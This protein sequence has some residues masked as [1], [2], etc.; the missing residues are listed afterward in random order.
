V[1][2]DYQAVDLVRGRLIIAHMSDASVVVVELKDGAVVKVVPNVPVPRG[3]AVAN[4]VKRVFVTSSPHTLVVL[5]ADSLDEIA[6]IPTGTA[7]DGVAWDGTHRVVAVSAQTDGAVSLI[8]DAGSGK[9]VDVRLGRETGNVVYD[10]Q[11]GCFWVAVE[12]S[13]P[14][15]ALVAVD[16][17][18]GKKLRTIPLPGC[19]AAHG[20]L[21]PPNSDAAFVACEDNAHLARVPL[22][23]NG[24]APAL[25][26]TGA[27]PDVLAFDAGLGWLYVAAESGDLTVFE[28]TRP[29]F[30]LLGRQHPADASHSVAVDP[31]THRVYFPLA[32][33]QNG[34]PTLRIMQPS[35]LGS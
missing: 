10:P 16:P 34:A 31:T 9:R 22:D 17:L 25:A 27:S 15:D 20:V 30:A 21:V 3:V 24:G 29:G 23:A 32:H 18:G 4:E 19:A 13:Q 11:R 12:Q 26:P 7:P 2:F 28:L 33:G 8:A 5:D 35:G 1:R 6:R 14:P